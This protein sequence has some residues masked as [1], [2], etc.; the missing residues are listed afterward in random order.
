MT[1]Y[2][3]AVRARA[4]STLGGI[5]RAGWFVGPVSSQPGSSSSP[6]ERRRCSGCSSFAVLAHRDA[7][8]SCLTLQAP[9]DR[10]A[11]PMAPMARCTHRRGGTLAAEGRTLAVFQTIR[12]HRAVLVRM[13]SEPGSSRGA[14]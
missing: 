13:A 14:G 3:A 7:P 5:F 1:S 6:A 9:L 4:L 11:W 10:R 8:C 2:V 12:N